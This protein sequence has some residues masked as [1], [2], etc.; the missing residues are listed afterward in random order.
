MRCFSR[1]VGT[2]GA[3]LVAAATLTILSSS[4]VAQVPKG[5]IAGKVID[6]KSRE[7]LIGANV[8]LE[9][10]LLGAAS[11]PD[12]SYYILNVP[13]GTYTLSASTIGYRKVVIKDVTVVVDRTMTVNFS[14]EPT[15]V[16][17]EAVVVEAKRPAVVRDLTSTAVVLESR[18]IE[19]APIEGLRQALEL[20]AALMQNPNGT[21]SVRGGPAFELQFQINGVEQITSNSGVPAY[22]HAFGDRA[23]TSWKFDYNP[24]GVQQMEVISGGFSAEYGNA[25]SGVVKVATKEGGPKITGE[26]RLEYRPAGKYH[27]GPYLYG[28]ETVEW[29]NWGRFEQWQAWR[30]Q[31][32]PDIPDD[33]LKV[34]YYDKWIANH[35]PGSNNESNPLGVYD[36][37][38][39]SYTRYLWG[40][41]GP[42]GRNDKLTFFFS[43]EYR[44]KPTRLPSV[45]RVQKYGNYNLTFTYRPAPSHKI[46]FSGS[47]QSLHS[48][49]WSGSEDIRWASAIGQ[50]PS[51]KYDLVIDSPK[52]EVTTT[53]SLSWTNTLSPRTFFELSVWHQRE[54]YRATN[55]PTIQSTDP[56]LAPANKLWDEDFRRP[57]YE[58]TSLYYL[59]NLTDVVNGTFDLISQVT[60][61]HQL[62]GGVKL[63]YWDTRHNGESGAR[64]NA[65]VAYS[66]F[67]EYYHAHPYYFAAYLQ[68]KM[69][70]EGMVA[71]VGV[72]FDGYNSNVDTPVDRFRPFYPATGQG[73]GP[74]VGDR[75]NPQTRKPKT[76]M[77]LA[78]RFG[79][80][81]PIGERTAFRLQYG[82]FY[83]MPIFRHTLSRTTW[84]GWWNYGNPDLGPKKT[85]SYEAGLQQSLGGTHRLDIAA[86]YNDRVSQTVSVRVHS[87]T[88]SQQQESD[89]RKYYYASFEN[90]GYGASRGIEVSLEKVS[91]GVWGY[92][93]SYHFSRTSEGAYGTQDVYEDPND[94]RATLTRRSANDAIIGEDRTHTFRA[95]VSYRVPKDRGVNLFGLRPFSHTD[96]SLIYTAQS[97][98]PYTYVAS[99]DQFREG[100]QNNRR[101]PLE[102]KT[103]GSITKQISFMGLSLKLAVR[104]QNLFNNRWL[105]P[106]DTAEEL[107]NWV[108]YSITRD[109]PP[110]AVDPNHRAAQALIYKLSY[111][112]TYR[113]TPRE[114][115]FSVGFAF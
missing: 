69:E 81:F 108:K 79:L 66:G 39:L 47:Y 59:D 88:G 71:N 111:F 21:Y 34:Y 80:S 20:S 102:A 50:F 26:F 110:E 64:V 5:K 78:P 105:T 53:Q 49:V 40:L 83:S 107:E 33:S 77:R 9:G 76:H 72:R 8:V 103:D 52:G 25:Q 2:F 85:I 31:N 114:V 106:L 36:Y 19:R 45:E 58:F 70:F 61:R 65:Y 12:G 112:R 74:F 75:G 48:A 7:P 51:W 86:Y 99:F 57:I 11:Q 18:E 100:V 6:A 38:K 24:I 89:P 37:T 55:V 22:S 93:L 35:S 73:G 67:A 68:D 4:V 104:F 23:N 62:K 60:P 87:P 32:A 1:Q 96:F 56:R 28:Q 41:G 113:N 109:T 95:L 82:H 27:F 43:G 15:V 84:Q 13:P 46:K 63:Q 98:V 29:K 91:P 115:Y 14:L 30:D 17:M 92:R 54:R 44:N 94:P 3:L 10:T 101:Y 42:V 16:E 97:G 90:N